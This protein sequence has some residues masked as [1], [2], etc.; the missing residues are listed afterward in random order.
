MVCNS[1]YGKM[2]EVKIINRLNHEQI[3]KVCI[4]CGKTATKESLY[5]KFKS[6]YL[7]DFI[8]GYMEVAN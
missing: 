7:V 5:Y 6:E 1:C 2:V 3:V 4:L 8:D